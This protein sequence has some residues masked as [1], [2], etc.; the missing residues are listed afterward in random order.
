[1]LGLLRKAGVDFR[2]R[3]IEVALIGLWVGGEEVLPGGHLVPARLAAEREHRRP[4]PPGAGSALAA[5]G[6][7]L[8]RRVAARRRTPEPAGTSTWSPSST[9]VARPAT[10]T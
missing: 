8:R 10:T 6:V 3:P 2:E 4:G 5:P 7:P 9:N 1:M